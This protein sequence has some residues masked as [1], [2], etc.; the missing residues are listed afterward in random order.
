MKADIIVVNCGSAG[1]L[2]VGAEQA[3]TKPGMYYMPIITNIHIFTL[4]PQQMPVNTR[5]RLMDDCSTNKCTVD[6]IMTI[7]STTYVQELEVRTKSH[8]S[9]LQ[10]DQA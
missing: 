10:T 7:P 8:T 2:L 9:K 4:V 1:Q 5:P 3:T 6:H